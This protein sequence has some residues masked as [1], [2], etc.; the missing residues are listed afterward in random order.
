MTEHAL[1]PTETCARAVC[2]MPRRTRM[3]FVG[4]LLTLA[5][6]AVSIPV[7]SPRARVDART[8]PATTPLGSDLSSLPA[9]H[10]IADWLPLEGPLLAGQLVVTVELDGRSVRAILDTGS[11]VSVIS[12]PFMR[13]LGLKTEK[14]TTSIL[15]AH[16]DKVDG[17]RT[18]AA[19]LLIG[20]RVFNDVPLLVFG[21]QPFRLL[22][23]VDVL[24]RLDLVIAVDEGLLG[25]FDARAAPLEPA[26]AIV[27]LT[28]M[29]SLVTVT[30]RAKGR[31][32][33]ATFPL[34]VDT[35]A[36]L[37]AVPARSGMRAGLP[38]DLSF[39]STTH[40][41][42]GRQEMRGRFVLDPLVLDPGGFAVSRVYA[43]AGVIDKGESF[44]LLGN[45]VLF[46]YRTTI[47]LARHTL[48]L[49][50]L[51]R[52]PPHRLKGPHGVT[53][54]TPCVEV[55]LRRQ[56]PSGKPA[57]GTRSDRCLATRVSRVFTGRTAE[58]AVVGFARDGTPL[59][60]GIRVL[61]TV[62]PAGIDE[63]FA[64]PLGMAKTWPD[65]AELSLQHL[66]T[67]AVR[68]TCDP[69]ATHCL[70]F[71]GPLPHRG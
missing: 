5:L 41:M 16:G 30:G 42:G 24:H 6:V 53:C 65:D 48:A 10:P 27:P 70:Q 11:Q 52:R 60:G 71:T 51:E 17:E 35:G 44:G 26:A 32:G 61:T 14:T 50:P 28:P 20:R 37:T 29:R 9:H 7:A 33:E 38:A 39:S 12:E 4:R 43:H 25:V 15:D 57:A 55:A 21:E 68:W 69:L 3:V 46:R 31:S 49:A 18:R 63:C 13:E 2:G 64:L 23:G 22:L 47:S 8:L 66:R 34:L 54:D 58:M 59:P 40:S 1:A 56:V 36:S 67:E 45:D 62:G 19:V